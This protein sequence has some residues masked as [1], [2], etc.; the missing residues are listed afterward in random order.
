MVLN[1]SGTEA[2]PYQIT[3]SADWTEIN[4]DLTAYYELQNDIDFGNGA[5]ASIDFSTPFSGTID[6]AGYAI[7]N[8][9]NSGGYDTS[10]NG[11]NRALINDFEG[12]IKNIVLDNWGLSHGSTA[13]YI[14]DNLNGGNLTDITVKNSNFS[15]TGNGV[16]IV[17]S[18]NGSSEVVS[19]FEIIDSTFEGTEGAP[20]FA[21]QTNS[22]VDLLIKN[23]SKTATSD[24]SLYVLVRPLNLEGL[25]VVNSDFETQGTTTFNSVAV[26]NDISNTYRDIEID[27]VNILFPNMNPDV[28]NV[29][30]IDNTGTSSATL[31]NVS[32][33]NVSS[34]SGS[35]TTRIINA[36][37]DNVSYE[38]IFVT[39]T[40]GYTIYNDSGSSNT[41]TDAYYNSETTDSSPSA[42][43]ALT[44]SEMTG[45][46]AST[47][48]N[49][50]FTNDWYTV[51]NDY[52]RL[53][54]FYNPPF[55]ADITLNSPEDGANFVSG[56][57]F[58][59]DFS[60]TNNEGSI[61]GTVNLNITSPDSSTSNPISQTLA[62]G[63]S[64]TYNSSGNSYTTLGSGSWEVVV[65]GTDREPATA[66]RTFEIF[67]DSE[68]SFDLD[69]TDLSR[70]FFDAEISGSDQV[71]YTVFVNGSERF[72]SNLTPSE[73]GVKTRSVDVSGQ[74][75]ATTVAV[76][77]ETGQNSTGSGLEVFN[78][79]TDKVI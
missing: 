34:T 6:G 26:I 56:E 49:F 24:S 60:V 40:S 11:S 27:N 9:G 50:D 3:S 19:N 21:F 64:N 52:P 16:A 57:T 68:L 23:V 46:A 53:D 74:S 30:Q 36:E 20:F 55:A 10:Q 65:D 73:H 66:S 18:A 13:A 5:I 51:D 39:D 12:E 42:F 7:R 78:I 61:D 29:L 28:D 25:R 44:T 71:S 62:A 79:R 22:I 15:S 77:V 41:V 14:I 38:D 17:S 1:G 59:F 33:R 35:S 69:A 63:S 32:I 45:S 47:N 43:T 4:N 54:N 8:V 37:S 31:K 2:D 76:R 48:M 75:G 72:S 70:V 58:A 67:D